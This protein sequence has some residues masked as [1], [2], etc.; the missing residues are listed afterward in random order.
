MSL[1]C[2]YNRRAAGLNDPPTLRNASN[3]DIADDTR[4]YS[5]QLRV[6]QGYWFKGIFPQI[7]QTRSSVV[8]MIADRTAIRRT[9]Y[10]QTIEQLLV[11]SWRT[12]GTHDPIQQAEFVN[13]PNVNPLKRDW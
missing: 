3:L 6:N 8:A 12:V 2:G 9:V 10:W 5:C 7:R 13:A 1:D 4:R 11:T